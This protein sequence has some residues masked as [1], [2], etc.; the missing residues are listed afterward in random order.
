MGSTETSDTAGQAVVCPRH[1]AI[2]EGTPSGMTTP[3]SGA[4]QAVSTQSKKLLRYAMDAGLLTYRMTVELRAPESIDRLRGELGDQV[5]LPEDDGVY[6]WVFIPTAA[7]GR[8]SMLIPEGEVVATIRVLAA[9][10]GAEAARRFDDR[11]G[12]IPA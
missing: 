11:P 2:P 3:L 5:Q 9:R 7:G 12:V 4:G 6:Y 10:H 1:P 8:Q